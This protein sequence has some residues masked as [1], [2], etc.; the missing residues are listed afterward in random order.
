M[1]DPRA[2][3]SWGRYTPIAAAAADWV[4]PFSTGG[5]RPSAGGWAEEREREKAADWGAEAS[6]PRP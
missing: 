2:A 4:D 3:R 5:L 6:S 1:I